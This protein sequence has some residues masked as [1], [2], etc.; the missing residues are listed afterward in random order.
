MTLLHSLSLALL[1]SEPCV[2]QEKLDKKELLKKLDDS[3]AHYQERVDR[4]FAQGWNIRLASEQDLHDA[5]CEQARHGS[6]S[7]QY[8]NNGAGY[9][10]LNRYNG[11]DIQGANP[12]YSFDIGYDYSSGTYGDRKKI[13]KKMNVEKKEQEYKSFEFPEKTWYEISKEQTFHQ[14]FFLNE[15][16]WK[17]YMDQPYFQITRTAD[18]SIG[19]E[20][21]T[22]IDFTSHHP[23]GDL[24]L[25]DLQEGS[26]LFYSDQFWLPHSFAVVN[27]RKGF[28]FGPNDVM[29]DWVYTENGQFTYTRDPL[30]ILKSSVIEHKG[31]GP[32]SHWHIRSELEYLPGASELSF[33][34]F[35]V[36]HYGFAEPEGIVWVDPRA[37]FLWAVG[38]LVALGLFG[39]FFLVK[40]KV[41]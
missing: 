2:F 33:R 24:P 20:R 15:K 26:L 12:R 6:R 35:T 9:I 8:L 10:L 40:S 28:A 11:H 4:H 23:P 38:G 37:Q 3:W 36:G 17:F 7:E 19:G 18:L 16:N 5:K 14:P 34:P 29:P 30:P 27:K 25:N 41:R 22:Q 32:E 39:A 1:L 31:K 21:I 13:I